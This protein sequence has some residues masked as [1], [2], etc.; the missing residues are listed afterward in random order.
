MERWRGDDAPGESSE[1]LPHHGLPRDV[2]HCLG[3]LYVAHI[4]VTT[5]LQRIT[6]VR[7]DKRSQSQ[8][9]RQNS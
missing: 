9:A 2:G 3:V 5:G 4:I 6:R 1:E 8:S 7:L